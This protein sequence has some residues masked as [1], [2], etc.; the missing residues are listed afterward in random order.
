MSDM[1]SMNR[2]I[3]KNQLR[4]QIVPSSESNQQDSEEIIKRARV[5]VRKKRI[6]IFLVL[7]LILAA[8]GIGVYTYF[9]Y[10]TYIRY[11]VVW[12]KKLDQGSYVGYLDFGTNVLKYSKD[13]ASYLDSQG[14]EV[15][16]QSYEMKTPI[17]SVNGD[18]AAI[19]DQE[20]NQIYIFDKHGNTG[21]ASTVLPVVKVTVSAH[22]V[23]AAILEDSTSN[24][25]YFFKRDGSG[26]DVQIKA[27]LGGSS[28]YPVDVS[29]S[30]DGTQLMGAYA[31]LKNGALNGRVAFHNFAEIGKSIPDRLV[32]GFDEPYEASLVAQVHFFDDTHSCAF[33]DNGI[34]FYSTKN[35][36]SPELLKQIK[37]EDE[38]KS[39]FCSSQ[40]AGIIVNHPEG[41]NPYRLDVYKS[42]GS[43]AFTKAFKYPYKQ[44]DIDG[45]HV[46]L[47]NEDSCRV[48][49]MSGRLKFSGTFD[50]PI[51]K[52]R[53][54]RFPNTLIVTGPQNMKEI[55]LQLGGQYQ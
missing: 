22:G 21:V 46:I 15:W 54:G 10:Y 36:L 51:S 24:Y 34:S 20:G 42:N 16:I 48:Y 5:K 52:I 49:N 3:K 44:G 55:K 19:A 38:M 33:G 30:P 17:A 8:G 29:L 12:D 41:E 28:G 31:Y 43:L 9:T 11:G 2:E 39:V 25:I 1:N 40:Y 13:G 53:N 4:R 47:Y 27:L 35:A 14:K 6:K 7:F 18:Y 23:V 50:F 37:V 26:I 32:G 45:D